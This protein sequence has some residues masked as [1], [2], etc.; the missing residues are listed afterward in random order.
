MQD[1]QVQWYAVATR[2]RHE[3]V[4]AEQ[5]WQKQIECFLPLKE[6]LSRWKDRRKMVQFPLFPGYLFVHVPIRARRLDILKVPSVVRVIGFQGEPEPIPEEQIQSVKTLVFSQLPFDPYPYINEG[7]L[8]EITRGPLRGLVGRLIEKK[9]KFKFV[10]SV[11]LIQQAVA[12]EV[13]ASD[14]Q[15]I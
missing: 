7:D 9:S 8:V 3:K 5:L 15:K 13:D 1:E 6:V 4:V 12:C 11:D 2:S 10:L 14:V